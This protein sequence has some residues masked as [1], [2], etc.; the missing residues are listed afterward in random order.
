[1]VSALANVVAVTAAIMLAAL[2]TS[3][4]QIEQG[5]VGVY[6]RGGAMLSTVSEPGYH[7][8]MPFL[9]R[10]RSIQV[11]MQK[12]EVLNVPCGT[13]GGVMIYFDKI[14]VV[15]IL[16]ASH[17]EDTISKF[18]ADYDKP[19][20]FDKVHHEL[21]Q[22]CSSH[23]LQEVYVDKFDRIDENLRTALQN[24]LTTLAPG[25]TVLN[26]RVTKPK[27]P[28]TIRQN[29]EQ[30]E[31]EKTKLLIAVQAQKV[32]EKQ[33]ETERKQAVIEAEK[34]AQVKKIRID[35][36]LVERES[37]RQMS[38]IDDAA[39]LA[40]E[41][42]LVDAEFY[43][44]GKAAEANQHRLTPEYLELTRLQSLTQTTKIY[45]G[46]DIPS[47]FHAIGDASG[48]GGGSL[49]AGA[50][51]AGDGDGQPGAGPG[52]EGTTRGPTEDS[53]AAGKNRYKTNK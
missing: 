4:H 50:G 12:D 11:T 52:A 9:D 49:D 5:H 13:S 39:M 34:H 19:L 30:M 31:A 24:D 28:E 16:Q 46:P 14:E 22:F 38:A 48:G 43:K 53:I 45:F 10:V 37:Q 1:M 32:A 42:A 15:N 25:L 44:Q 33:S 17:V 21:N 47:F 23:S 20:I 6:F 2:S 36:E 41:K 7:V 29:Y 18:T 35:A 51:A 40:R 8:M 3:L 27:I 26:V